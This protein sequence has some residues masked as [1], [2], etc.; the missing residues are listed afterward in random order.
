[1]AEL[2]INGRM[3]VKNFRKQFKEELSI[4]IG[5]SRKSRKR[6]GGI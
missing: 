6:V 5:G 3:V 4:K 1:M 2:N